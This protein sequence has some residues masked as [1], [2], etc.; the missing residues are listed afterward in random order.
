M[1]LPRQRYST[2]FLIL[3]NEQHLKRRLILIGLVFSNIATFA[4]WQL[5][6]ISILLSI[7]AIG[8]LLW[9]IWNQKVSSLTK[10]SVSIPQDDFF[11]EKR[12]LYDHRGAKVESI[13]LG[14]LVRSS[15]KWLDYLLPHLDAIERHYDV[16]F[17][18][19]F[20]ENDSEDDTVAK[21]S[22]FLA[23][24]RFG[25]LLSIGER[26]VECRANRLGRLGWLRNKL[27]EQINN[28]KVNFDWILL[29]D[30]EVVFKAE[31]I[32]D[33]FH[34]ASSIPHPKEVVGLTPYVE[35]FF[36]DDS[37]KIL[38]NGHYFDT[39]ALRIGGTSFYPHCPFDT[40][41]HCKINVVSGHA[42]KEWVEIDAGFGG[43][44]LIDGQIFRSNDVFWD[45]GEDLKTCEHISFFDR[46]RSKNNQKVI[47]LT[48]LRAQMGRSAKTFNGE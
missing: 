11:E 25:S 9:V 39:F 40:C 38:T 45:D 7:P 32:G 34:K 14:V 24:G 46:L 17:S 47:L 35:A 3:F 8:V 1:Y 31:I 30:S 27:R 33:L 48:T 6:M 44:M 16:T 42:Q 21:L 28:A 15:S 29:M 43:F 10:I 2:D 19:F 5:E 18:Y 12:P 13:A 22:K 37:N 20:V 4:A 26:S 36:S 41:K 23:A